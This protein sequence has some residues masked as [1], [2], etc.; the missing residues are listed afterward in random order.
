MVPAGMFVYRFGGPGLPQYE[1]RSQEAIYYATVYFAIDQE[2]WDSEALMEFMLDQIRNG[3]AVITM[4]PLHN[5]HP[6][7]ISVPVYGFSGAVS[8]LVIASALPAAEIYMTEI[9][10]GFIEIDKPRLFRKC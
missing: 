8:P 3:D 4:R 6:L 10:Q 2:S 7:C 5:V 9:Q 1:I